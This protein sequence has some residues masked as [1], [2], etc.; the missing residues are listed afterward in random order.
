MINSSDVIE[1]VMLNK[2]IKNDLHYFEKKAE[3]KYIHIKLNK[4]ILQL[5]NK[6]CNSI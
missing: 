6:H 5:I 2:T 4:K 1:T 3:I